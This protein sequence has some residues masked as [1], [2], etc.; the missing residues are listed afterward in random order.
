MFMSIINVRRSL[1]CT[2]MPPSPHPTQR[3]SARDRVGMV[4]PR[5]GGWTATEQKQSKKSF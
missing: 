4:G 5:A 3:A 2:K 1:V